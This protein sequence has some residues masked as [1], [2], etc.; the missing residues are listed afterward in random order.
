MNDLQGN[1]GFI[2]ITDERARSSNENN[3]TRYGNKTSACK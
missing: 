1:S 2:D 3:L